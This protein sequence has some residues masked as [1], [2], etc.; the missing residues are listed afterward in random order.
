MKHLLHVATSYFIAECVGHGVGEIAIGDLNGIREST[1][2]GHRLNQRL[3]A[4]PYRK[5]I[6][7]L[8]YK[9]EL[10]G[11]VVRD[12]VDEDNTSKTCCACGMVNA[13][14]RRHQRLHMCSCD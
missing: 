4:W 9:G 14:N 12:D 1:H 8:K 5:L 2:Y 7:M 6:N 10:A 13:S 11:I 3:H